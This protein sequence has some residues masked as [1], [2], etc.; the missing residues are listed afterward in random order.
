MQIELEW[1]FHFESY[2]FLSK[3]YIKEFAALC[4]QTGEC[5]HK[6]VSIP[7][8]YEETIPTELVLRQYTQHGLLWRFGDIEQDKFLTWLA[9]SVPPNEFTSVYCCSKYVNEYFAK[10]Y[11]IQYLCH[12]ALQ[13]KKQTFKNI[14][15]CGAA[16][17]VKSP[18][19][20]LRTVL[21]MFEFL[22]PATVPYL[23]L[24]LVT[25]NPDAARKQAELRD[26]NA[27]LMTEHELI[28]PGCINSVDLVKAHHYGS[29]PGGMQ[30]MER[31]S[32]CVSVV[33]FDL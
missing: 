24:G 16:H 8:S 21:N 23:V 2:H 26:N 25:K 6:F 28:L 22:R 13:M 1:L 17:M 10:I 14:E 7:I 32:G 5:L 4:I 27:V 29:T 11:D 20:A 12:V 31:P 3:V 9:K 33:E 19:C 15:P 18:K 30:S